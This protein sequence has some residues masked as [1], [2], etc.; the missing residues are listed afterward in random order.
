VGERLQ[1]IEL[2]WDSLPEEVNPADLPPWHLAELE[3][4]RADANASPGIG[5]PWREVLDQFGT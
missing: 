1:L 4:R 2:I 3:K 5:K